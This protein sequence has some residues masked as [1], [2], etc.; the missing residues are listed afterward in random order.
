MMGK[1]ILS[2]TSLSTIL[3]RHEMSEK[4][5]SPVSLLERDSRVV[6][7]KMTMIE[8]CLIMPGIKIVIKWNFSKPFAHFLFK[9][10]NFIVRSSKYSNLADG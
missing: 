9:R 5:H 10:S 3:N 1:K 6:P 8:K 7:L 4:N 2:S